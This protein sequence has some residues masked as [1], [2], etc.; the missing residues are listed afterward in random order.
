MLWRNILS[1]LENDPLWS[2][3]QF[4]QKINSRRNTFQRCSASL[5][6]PLGLFHPIYIKLQL[7]PNR[8]T[9]NNLPT[10]NWTLRL[11][12]A[13]PSNYQVVLDN[14]A[15]GWAHISHRWVS[16][17]DEAFSQWCLGSSQTHE[18]K[19]DQTLWGWRC[20]QP[21]N[22]KKSLALLPRP[23]NH[24]KRLILPLPH[25]PNPQK[26]KAINSFRNSTSVNLLR[27]QQQPQLYRLK[28]PIICHL[29]RQGNL[30]NGLGKASPQGN[31]H[32]YK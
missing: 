16:V 31:N 3:K 9:A 26:Q 30:Q 22:I 13:S 10:S 24:E 27:F 29:S 19:P 20:C 1:S 6:M 14:D 18:L 8:N 11:A 2:K 25:P 4:Q 12:I 28:L 7:A 15:A 5:Q 23:Q 32:Q 17:P 21:K